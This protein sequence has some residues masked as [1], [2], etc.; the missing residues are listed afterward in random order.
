MSSN[1]RKETKLIIEIDTQL[2]EGDNNNNF[3]LWL[4]FYLNL[5]VN[6]SVMFSREK[7]ELKR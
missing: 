4:V 7:I 1:G 2:N 3:L 5:I 6:D